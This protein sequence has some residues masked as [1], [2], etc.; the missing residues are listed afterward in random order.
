M[1]VLAT[2]NQAGAIYSTR[3]VVT[4]ASTSSALDLLTANGKNDAGFVCKQRLKSISA[5]LRIARLI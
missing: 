4:I 5:I 1:R 2:S 3:T